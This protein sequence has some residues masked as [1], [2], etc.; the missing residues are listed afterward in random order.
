MAVAEP[1]GGQGGIVPPG[2]LARRDGAPRT[3]RTAPPCG[4]CCSKKGRQKIYVHVFA[5]PVKYATVA[6]QENVYA[7]PGS[8]PWLR[9]CNM[10]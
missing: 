8:K 2:A 9:H 3:P 1:G 5:A 10:A 7:P 6:P 4:W